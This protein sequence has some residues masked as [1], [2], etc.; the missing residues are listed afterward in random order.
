MP[1]PPSELHKFLSHLQSE[2]EGS[3]GRAGRMWSLVWHLRNSILALDPGMSRPAGLARSPKSEQ[4][5]IS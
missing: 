3:S 4:Q 5:L 2:E 1:W